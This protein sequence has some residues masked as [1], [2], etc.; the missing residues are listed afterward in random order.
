MFENFES[1]AGEDWGGE[2]TARSQ[3]II[4]RCLLDVN[5]CFVVRMV[6]GR[7]RSSEKADLWRGRDLAE[8]GRS[9]AA[10]LHL[11]FEWFEGR[12]RWGAG[13]KPAP[14]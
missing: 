1:F 12:L 9:S 4:A 8:L 7:G 13:F 3:Q 6:K 10:P 5:Y 2:R 11:A 14:F